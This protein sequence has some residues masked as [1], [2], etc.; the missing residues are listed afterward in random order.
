MNTVIHSIEIL[1]HLCGKAFSASAKVP[2]C[3]LS[4]PSDER[5]KRPSGGVLEC[6]QEDAIVIVILHCGLV[7]E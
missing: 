4:A 1:F 6:L 2:D 7:L 3:K 5:R